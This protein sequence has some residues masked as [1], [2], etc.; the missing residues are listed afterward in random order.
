MNARDPLDML[1]EALA[2]QH[3]EADN[4]NSGRDVGNQNSVNGDKTPPTM[5]PNTRQRT[6]RMTRLLTSSSLKKG[7]LQ[8][9]NPKP[10]CPLWIKVPLFILFYLNAS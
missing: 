6:I 3:N 7:S 10:P 8:I 5:S 9:K 4:G 2:S 1:V